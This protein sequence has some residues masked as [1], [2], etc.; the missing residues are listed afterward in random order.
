MGKSNTNISFLDL[1]QKME[2]TRE[3]LNPKRVC[4]DEN[5]TRT[6]HFEVEN[7]ILGRV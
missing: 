1:K 3:G 5:D 7:Y 4:N 6:K 2:N